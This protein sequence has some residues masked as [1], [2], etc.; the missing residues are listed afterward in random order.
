MNVYQFIVQVDPMIDLTESVV[1]VC[2]ENLDQ[3]LK[4]V[5]AAARSQF[6]DKPF[7]IKL[8]ATDTKQDF[9]QKLNIQPQVIV[10]PQESTPA[11]NSLPAM[12]RM[13]RDNGYIVKKR[14]I[15]PIK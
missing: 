2:T 10:Q 3:G 14:A 1:L 15:K 11:V 8:M 9:M 5:D 6:K 12:A 13:L 7:R 4:V